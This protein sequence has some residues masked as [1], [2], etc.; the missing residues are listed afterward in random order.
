[1]AMIT[2]EEWASYLLT[3]S[4]LVLLLITLALLSLA[5]VDTIERAIYRWKARKNKK[6]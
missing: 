3:G 5:I 2:G 6:S 1:M 4:V